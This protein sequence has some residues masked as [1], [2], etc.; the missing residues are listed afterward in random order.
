MFPLFIYLPREKPHI[1]K[2][3]AGW[4][5]VLPLKPRLPLFLLSPGW[6]Q[7]TTCQESVTR[8]FS[9]YQTP[10][11]SLSSVACQVVR[12]R[13]LRKPHPRQPASLAWKQLRLL[14]ISMWGFPSGILATFYLD[15]QLCVS[16]TSRRA[17]WRRAH[18]LL[19]KLCCP[20]WGSGELHM[21]DYGWEV[22]SSFCWVVERTQK[23][24]SK[25]GYKSTQ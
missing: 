10:G 6:K 7:S 4:F 19:W 2:R 24:N 5:R 18:C 25:A 23:G 12:P 15:R 22:L 3:K 20:S 14:L 13:H 8:M 21:S 17:D 16:I 1:S 9:Q 11:F